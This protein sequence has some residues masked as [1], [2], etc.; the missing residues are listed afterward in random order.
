MRGLRPGIRDV[1]F[2]RLMPVERALSREV[3]AMVRVCSRVVGGVDGRDSGM[4]LKHA[5][6]IHGED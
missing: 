1:I 4:F 6:G 3:A 5:C 2:A